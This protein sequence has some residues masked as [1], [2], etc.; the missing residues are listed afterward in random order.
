MPI[1]ITASVLLVLSVV[2]VLFLRKKPDPYSLQS[3]TDFEKQKAFREAEEAEIDDDAL[4]I[5]PRC[6]E[7]I[8]AKFPLCPRCTP[9]N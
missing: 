5:C 1:V 2:V 4:P 6:G 3:L 7:E 9:R 8:P